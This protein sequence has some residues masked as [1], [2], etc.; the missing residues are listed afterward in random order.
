MT[1]GR[2]VA[3]SHTTDGRQNVTNSHATV[4]GLDYNEGDSY[5]VLSS[6]ADSNLA[7]R[8]SHTVGDGV[9]QQ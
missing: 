2:D 7:G 9:S 6:S 5:I 1:G 3:H 8:V 4:G